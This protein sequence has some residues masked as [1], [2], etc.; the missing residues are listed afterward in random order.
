MAFFSEAMNGIKVHGQVASRTDARL[1]AQD[2]K[3]VSVAACGH[4]AAKEL[5][6][7]LKAPNHSV[8]RTPDGAAYLKR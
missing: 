5:S 8:K 3:A 2:G 6:A 1:R 4:Q 7:S